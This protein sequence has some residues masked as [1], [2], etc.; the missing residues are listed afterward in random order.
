MKKC[1]LPLLP[2]LAFAA[3]AQLAACGSSH[4]DAT[5]RLS[6]AITV[7]GGVGT[8]SSVGATTVRVIA[9]RGGGTATIDFPCSS[10]NGEFDIREGLYDIEVQLLDQTG[11]RLNSV[12]VVLTRDLFADDLVNLGLFEF[13]FVLNFNASFRVH[14]GSAEVTGGNCNSTISNGA[15]VALEE[16]RIASGS[17]CLAY[18]LSGV[19]NENDQPIVTDTCSQLICQ[20]NSVIHTVEGLSPGSYQIQVI[21]YKGATGATPHACYYSLAT[22]FS[23]TNADTNLGEIFAPFDPLPADDVF[24]NATKPEGA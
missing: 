20:P 8:C 6:W 17:Q 13:S 15:G 22:P 12:P 19:I 1:L 23:I 24:C 9:I 14:M 4:N 10:L 18:T 7:N 21:G 16:I 11:L 2:V 5:V 3:T